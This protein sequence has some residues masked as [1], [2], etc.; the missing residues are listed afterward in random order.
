MVVR[1]VTFRG[2]Q[3]FG[4][5]WE[6]EGMR[7]NLAATACERRSN[8]PFDLPVT[9]SLSPSR[10][11]SGAHSYTTDSYALGR[12]L[13]RTTDLSS[14]AIDDFMTKI[15]AGSGARLFRVELNDQT[16]RDVGYFVD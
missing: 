16:L 14:V 3:V 4:A 11:V 10:G 9:V 12:L 8:R 13:R 5:G 1:H 2:I 6:H 15:K 7:M